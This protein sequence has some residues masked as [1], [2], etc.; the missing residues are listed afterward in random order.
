M[1]RLAVYLLVFISLIAGWATPAMA[2]KRVALV[3][4]NSA[5]DCHALN[6]IQRL[7]GEANLSGRGMARYAHGRFLP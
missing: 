5:Y 4:G 2:A 3:I 1:L 6:S 7:V